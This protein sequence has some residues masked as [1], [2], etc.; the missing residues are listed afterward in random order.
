MQ[1]HFIALAFVAVA[2]CATM[3]EEDCAT[4]DWRYIGET[5]GYAGEPE[6]KF[7]ERADRCAKFGFDADG[8][9][10][11]EGRDRGLE[12]YCTPD[13]GYETGRNGGAYRGVCPIE[14]EGD[15]LAEY[16]IGRRLYDLS[17]AHQSA[18]ESYESALRSLES[19]RSNIKRARD[20]LRRDDITP[21]ERASL[22]RD[23]DR[24]RSEN[25]RLERE[26]PRLELTIDQALGRLEDY[27]DYLDRRGRRY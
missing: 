18:V 6:E 14:S 15:F 4:A 23:I 12:T 24:Y 2:G 5:D 9:A 8:R 26:L 1:R 13:N 11:H 10:Y 20:R 17:S 22:E 3:S 21:E 25:D 27:R 7:I 16:N 19:N